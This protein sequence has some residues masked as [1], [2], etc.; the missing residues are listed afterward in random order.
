MVRVEYDMC[1]HQPKLF[2]RDAFRSV[3]CTGVVSVTLH[4][5]N[6]GSCSSMLQRAS[7]E[8]HV[9]PATIVV[10]RGWCEKGVSSPA[11]LQ[12]LEQNKST[13]CL[14]HDM[15]KARA[16]LSINL[17]FCTM[18]PKGRWQNKRLSGASCVQIVDV[19]HGKIAI[20]EKKCTTLAPVAH[21]R[22]EL[23]RWNI[24]SQ[25]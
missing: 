19:Y 24:A 16:F 12:E 10:T 17:L 20:P 3:N 14:K 6:P 7:Q 21:F 2:F 13:S 4:A 11:F 1:V 25:P 22:R 18:V 9:K 15:Y 23:L 5:S 8:L